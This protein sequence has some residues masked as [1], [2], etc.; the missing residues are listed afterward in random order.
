MNSFTFNTK[1]NGEV[2]AVNAKSALSFNDML[3]FA[4]DII[5]GIFGTGDRASLYLRDFLI[6]S[7]TIQYYTD[8]EMPEDIN[9]IYDI[10]YESDLYEDTI[11]DKDFDY[12]QYDSLMIGLDEQIKY[13]IQKSASKTKLD[14]LFEAVTDVI[15]KFDGNLDV[16]KVGK[17]I[18]KLQN[19]EKI[20]EKVLAEAVLSLQQKPKKS[21]KTK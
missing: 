11:K 7:Y 3:S 13:E 5:T 9:E 21:K 14:D 18:D 8:Y 15:K 1:I 2:V 4:D 20:D 12:K 17:M 10:V 16:A 6:K 19:V